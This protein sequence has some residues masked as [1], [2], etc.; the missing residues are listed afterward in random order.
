[1]D[2]TTILVIVVVVALIAWFFY[3]RSRPAPRGTYDDK[4]TRSSGS[5]GGGNRA[6][7]DPAHRSSGSI[8]GGSRSYDSP[9]QESHGSIGGSPSSHSNRTERGQRHNDAIRDRDDSERH[10]DDERF[11]SK[12]SIGG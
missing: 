2:S 1:M 11:K 3:N 4:R 6:Y 12:G 7:D 9:K 5:I 8:G 10:H